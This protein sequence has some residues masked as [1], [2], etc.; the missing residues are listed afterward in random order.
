MVPQQPCKSKIHI[1]SWKCPCT[2]LQ[3]GSLPRLNSKS[4]SSWVFGSLA[5]YPN[6]PIW[7]VVVDVGVCDHFSK[8]DCCMSKR[9]HGTL[10][11]KCASRILYFWISFHHEKPKEALLFLVSVKRKKDFR[12]FWIKLAGISSR[13]YSFVGE[14]S[15]SNKIKKSSRKSSRWWN[16][17]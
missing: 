11:R 4:K 2:C 14:V 9:A 17:L 8:S 10:T 6:E 15:Q 1:P 7:R 12:C 3:S 16:Y 13:N 5:G